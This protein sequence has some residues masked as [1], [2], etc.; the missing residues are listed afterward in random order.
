[1]IILAIDTSLASV[2]ACVF[3]GAANRM[4]ASEAILMKRGHS[5]ALM[6]LVERVVT[7]VPG[8]FASLQR[9][10][11]TVGPGSFTGIRVGVA[12]ARAMAIALDVPVVG[13]STLAAF[14]SQ[15]VL[16]SGDSDIVAAIDA[17][18]NQ[19]YV[20]VFAANGRTILQ[21]Q[22][23]NP[24]DIASRL[25][26]GPIRATGSAGPIMV[27]EAWAQSITAEIAGEVHHPRIEFVARVGLAADPAFAPP[28]PLY[29]K[30]VDVTIAS[31]NPVAR[32]G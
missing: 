16:E 4:L 32:Q 26:K 17:R 22:I 11:V 20:Q 12:A 19:I 15:L 5:E 3:D 13:V 10:A 28:N 27:L 8:G 9:I 30:A 6:P 7:A 14:A 24:R 29:L 21:P 31:P 23:G 25:G 2:C 18:H 1:M